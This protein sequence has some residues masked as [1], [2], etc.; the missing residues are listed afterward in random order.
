[1]RKQG[2]GER[3]RGRKTQK[4]RER[5]RERQKEKKEK[6][7]ERNSKGVAM[8]WHGKTVSV[9]CHQNHI[10]KYKSKR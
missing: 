5:E 10:L 8:A 7:S 3:G 6:I 9:C 1:M 2:D 4:E